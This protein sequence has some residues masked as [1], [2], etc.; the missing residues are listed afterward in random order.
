VGS[1]EE[2][3]QMMEGGQGV[4]HRKG[5]QWVAQRRRIKYHHKYV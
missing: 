1:T 2:E 3:G 5:K 4:D